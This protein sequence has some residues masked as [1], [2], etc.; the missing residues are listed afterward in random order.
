MTR[1]LLVT[2][3]FTAATVNARSH[4]TQE[5][6]RRA[7]YEPGVLSTTA[8]LFVLITLRDP[9]SGAERAAAV[10]GPFLLGAIETE[11]QVLLRKTSRTHIGEALTEQQQK[12]VQ[13]ALAHPNRV[14]TFRNRRARNNVEPRYTPAMLGEVQR[15]LATKSR[16][17]I[18]AAARADQ[19]W[20]HQIYDSRRDPVQ[21]LAYRDAVAHAL[22][23][24]GIL[25]GEGDYSDGLY[26][27]DEKT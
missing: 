22:L 1:A 24:H 27:A 8:P 19:S 17:E 25:V 10:P 2:L 4:Y 3:L 16:K 18:L 11:Y 15:V 14:F 5:M 7:L 21:R 13:I 12:E 20:L 6:F 23:E 9:S 26:V